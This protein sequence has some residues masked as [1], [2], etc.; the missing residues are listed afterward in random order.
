MYGA[1]TQ[2]YMTKIQ[3]HD[4]EGTIERRA[5]EEET[6]SL[7]ERLKG[8]VRKSRLE[9]MFSVA[10]IDDD[11]A[12]EAF[13]YSRKKL[14]LVSFPDDMDFKR[15][16]SHGGEAREGA[17]RTLE[18]MHQAYMHDFGFT[19][20]VPAMMGALRAFRKAAS[21]GTD[22]SKIVISDGEGNGRKKTVL[23]SVCRSCTEIIRFAWENQQLREE[24]LETLLELSRSKYVGRTHTQEIAET[25]VFVKQMGVMKNDLLKW[26]LVE[27]TQK[28]RDADWD[29]A[30]SVAKRL[31]AAYAKMPELRNRL[32]DVETMPAW[33]IRFAFRQQNCEQLLSLWKA[34]REKNANGKGAQK[35]GN[36]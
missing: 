10:R 26:V 8:D 25:F 30:Y 5:R 9:F 36:P 1:L 18:L 23:Q 31:S 28:L 34:P 13:R 4:E 33:L 20:S 2:E 12:T 21:K 22:F 11:Y 35:L 27:N 19:Q 16:L 24:A 15:L 6:R 17:L 3:A 14:D 7:S 29:G 32:S